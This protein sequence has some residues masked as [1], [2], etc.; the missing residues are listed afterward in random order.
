MSIYTFEL[1]FILA[2][3]IIDCFMFFKLKRLSFKGAVLNFFFWLAIAL[4]FAGIIFFG[5]NKITAKE[6]LAGYFLE[7]TLSLDNI[8]V[9][10]VIFSFFKIN[11]E[12]KERVL[13]WGIVLA[14]IL[15]AIFIFVGA[16]LIEKF[17]FLMYIFALFLIFTGLKLILAKESEDKDFNNNR[18]VKFLKKILPTTDKFQD[19][20]FTMRI[21]GKLFFTPIFITMLLVGF[22]DIVFA[23]DSIPAI[24]GITKDPFVVA[25][26]NFF[27]LM[28]LRAIFYLI[29]HIMKHFYYIKYA[30]SAI[31]IFIGIK[32]MLAGFYHI[33]ITYSLAFIVGSIGLSIIASILFKKNANNI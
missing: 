12:G 26:A 18:I 23:L 19:D 15:R 14:I 8:F 22:T 27:S 33:P 20:D 28:G 6:F 1:V 17:S 31:L 25:T 30:L 7:R 5:F 32:M 13:F 4:I 10:Y 9:F 2:C 3:F 16:V 29:S 24:F 21:N 11:E